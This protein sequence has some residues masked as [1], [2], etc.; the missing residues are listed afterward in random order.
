MHSRRD[1]VRFASLFSGGI[2][3][4]GSASAGWASLAES[5][6]RAASIPPEPGS[7]FLDAEH[8]VILMQENRSFDHC[9][10][11]LRGVRGFSD[12]RAMRLA[13]DRPVW[14]QRDPRGGTFGPFHTD[15]TGT[16]TTWMGSLPHSWTDQVDAAA[17]G[18]HDQ[19]LEAKRPG[20]RRYADL[21]LTMGYYDRADLPFYYALADAFTVC[22]HNFCSSLTGTTPN[23]LYLW[24]GTCRD[25]RESGAKARVLNSDTDERREASW[26]TLP[27]RLEDAGVS[28]KIY[29]NE[30][31]IATGLEGEH[32]AWLANFSDNPI[33]WFSQFNVRFS[34]ARRAY[35]AERIREIPGEIEALERATHD[36]Q[37]QR[38]KAEKRRADLVRQLP[39]LREEAARYTQEAW[40]KL[41]A[42]QRSLHERAFSTNAGDAAYRELAEHRYESA[43][44][45]RRMTVPKGDTLHEFR[46]DVASGRLPAVSWLVP[47]ER[48]SDHPSS[49]WYGAWYL[50]EVIRILTENPEVWR[51]TIFVLTYDENDG[52]FDH[53][54]PF[55]APDP[56]DP[57]TGRVSAGI[58]ATPEFVTL[59]EE[60]HKKPEDRRQS[61]IGLGFRVPMI[62]ASPWSRGGAVCS[63]VFDHTSV[64]RLI[65]RVI[66]AR[67]GRSFRE[68]NITSWRRAVCGDMS[69]VFRAADDSVGELPFASREAVL[70]R[71]HRARDG[72]MP[73]A[74]PVSEEVLAEARAG[75]ATGAPT[76]ERGTRPACPLPYELTADAATSGSGVSI[77][78]S[79]AMSRFGPASAG[80][81][82]VVHAYG[83]RGAGRDGMAAR[84]YAVA[85]GESVA[86]EWPLSMFE[87]GVVDLVVRGPNGFVREYR[88]KP[89]DATVE[90][91]FREEVTG[92]GAELLVQV[93]HRGSAKVSVK[94]SDVSYGGGSQSAAV[95][96]GDTAVMRLRTD[97]A[98]GWY[99]VRVE[100]GRGEW[101]ARACGKIE[102]G[103][104]TI[105]DPLMGGVVG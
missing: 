72:A 33:E 50:A 76:Q 26:T 78:M 2:L 24:S 96:P 45:E 71:I 55:L 77:S 7:T 91:G 62:V 6:Q 3:G 74:T 43:S 65:E 40:E 29:Q 41:P 46:R 11:M 20:N 68:T 80:S 56:R 90:V 18:L 27:E 101:T 82:F 12:P 31:N 19:W 102:T 4:L 83:V 8:I 32:D 93:R 39:E 30:L 14:I 21:P 79:A 84:H 36:T 54:P 98:G 34:A 42:R 58:D 100:I 63:Q 99:D 23:R 13:D 28:W 64:V 94:V 57:S 1:F 85:A 95:E 92:A 53:V 49:P 59:A 61:S 9:F 47:P 105:T 104:W 37:E 10:G 87:G 75:R 25:P 22:D 60:S 89:A 69:S 88:G 5:V 103:R 86:D 66:S 52:Y 15:M 67:L 16:R 17:G 81:G 48:F 44:G 38:Q 51:R 73:E 97:R 70:E 35:V